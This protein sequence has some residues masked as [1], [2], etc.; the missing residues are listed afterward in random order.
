MAPPQTGNEI[1]IPL[2]SAEVLGSPTTVTWSQ[3]LFTRTA[4]YYP[5][6]V[7]NLT[8]GER[9]PFFIAAELYKSSTSANPNHISRVGQ[10]VP[11]GK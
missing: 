8:T 4:E 6:T 5:L 3:N 10:L 9:F 7:D 11:G 1:L 2:F